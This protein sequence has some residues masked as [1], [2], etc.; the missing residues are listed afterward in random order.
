[1][2]SGTTPMELRSD[3]FAGPAEIAAAIPSVIRAV[4]G[5]QSRVTVGKVRLFPNYPHTIPGEAVFNLIIRDTDETVLKALA[6]SFREWIDRTAQTRRLSVA[7]EET[8]WLSPVKLDAGIAAMVD[9]EAKHLGLAYMRMPSGAGHDAQTMQALCPSAL[10]FVPS[11]GGI[12]HSPGEWTDWA[13]IEGGAS[14]MLAALVRL[15]GAA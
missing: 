8:S 7:V 14:L 6:A 9:A 11:R 5:E 3:A 12:T 13:D 4:G 10:I 1:N 2:H 15:S